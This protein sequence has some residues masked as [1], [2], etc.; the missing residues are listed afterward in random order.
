MVELE[1]I[2]LHVRMRSQIINTMYAP[3]FYTLT[4]YC[5]VLGA[6]GLPCQH[7]SSTLLIGDMGTLV[8][9][10]NCRLASER[11]ATL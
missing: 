8:T 9:A 1:I 10:Y 2:L 3:K 11:T 5:M 6:S 7:L 4:S